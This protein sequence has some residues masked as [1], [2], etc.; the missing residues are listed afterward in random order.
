LLVVGSKKCYSTS[1]KL[2]VHVTQPSMALM[3]V[4]GSGSVSCE[5]T[6]HASDLSLEVEGSGDIKLDIATVG[7]NTLVEGSGDITVTGECSTLKATVTG[8][9][10][11][12][13]YELRASDAEAEV[14][15]SGDIHVNVLNN[16]NAEV[17]GSGDIKF[18]GDPIVTKEITGSGAVTK[19]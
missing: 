18:R 19:Q 6:L 11:V 13:A 2:I 17:T 12:D 5:G 7:L 15:G 3:R 10:N 4:K 14:T 8:S 9:G 1:E 16:L